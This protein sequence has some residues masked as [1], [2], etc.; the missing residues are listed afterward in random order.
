MRI[1]VAAVALSMMVMILATGIVRG[2][3]N[4]ISEKV[5]GFWGHIHISAVYGASHLAFEPVPMSKKQPF[6][7]HLDTVRSIMTA[8]VVA[9]EK[10]QEHRSRGGIRHIQVFANKEGI[11]KTQ[12]EIEGII[13]RGIGSDYD[14][15]FLQ[16]YIIEGDTLSTSCPADSAD[17][18]LLSEVTARRLKLKLGERVDIYFVNSGDATARRFR[19]KGIYKTGLEE[20]DRKFALVDIRQI[21]QLNNWRPFHN[22]GTE[23][24]LKEESA[25]LVALTN[26]T[27]PEQFANILTEGSTPDWEDAQK[28]DCVISQQF[29]DSRKLRVGDSLRLSYYASTD[30]AATYTGVGDSAKIS[31]RIS[32]IHDAQNRSSNTTTN[33]QPVVFLPYHVLQNLNNLLPQQVSGFEVFI[34]NLD[35]LDDYGIYIEHEVLVGQPYYSS[36]IK[37]LE[38]T[39]FDW[40]NLTDMNERIILL[41]MILVAIINMTTS[42]LILI[43]ERTNMIGTLKALGASNWTIRSIFLHYAAY[44]IGYGL[45]WGNL[46]AVAL[47]LAQ[48][49]FGLIQLPEDLYYISSVPVELNV[50]TMLTL[51]A[52]TLFITLLV[53]ILPSYLVSRIDP[54]KAIRFK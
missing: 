33:W 21:Q 11:I 6:Y 4:T 17:G 48:N 29:A 43:L 27:M 34:E 46:L 20:Y 45:F 50:L 30:I 1:A 44:I 53:L 28:S 54:V 7:P 24:E 10:P 2:F 22:F 9:G 35:D 15:K 49:Y 31:L 25:V 14:W 5:F 32:G 18:I 26:A 40:L 8:T 19:L 51:N 38:P 23:L 39:I 37:Q 42:L 12:D 36:T 16:Q 13:L 41:V 3:K 52:G 47:A